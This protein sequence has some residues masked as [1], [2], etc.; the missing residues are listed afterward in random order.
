M[1]YSRAENLIRHVTLR[2]LQIFEA[3]IR[4]GGYT[5][6][7]EALHLTQPTVSM[8]IKKLSESLGTP[9]IE[10]VG[11]HVQPTFAGKEVYA[12]TQVILEKMVELGDSISEQ[13][14]LIKGE[15][16][17]ACITSAKYFI[18]HLLAAF[19]GQHPDVKPQLTV[20]NRETVLK[21][22]KANE[23]DLMIVG[24]MPNNLIV[25]AYPMLDHELVAVASP[26]HPLCKKKKISLK[27]LSQER[28]LMRERGSGTRQA[29]E[30]LFAEHDLIVNQHMEL[31]SSEAIKQAVMAKLGI[32]VLSNFNLR[33]ELAGNHLAILD[34][35]GFPLNRKWYAVHSKEKKLS[36][37]TRTFLNFLLHSKF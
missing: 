27:E 4:L 12:T 21:R 36:L 10:Q 35:E 33:L 26:D 19:I 9:L 6:A 3:V 11:R 25:K 7:A 17:I 22:F 18:P 13:N 5:R 28:F 24:Q 37:L 31:D 2:Q 34:V 30:K 29:V 1:P 15:L 32:S 8:Q 23:D 16:R 20:T 14:G